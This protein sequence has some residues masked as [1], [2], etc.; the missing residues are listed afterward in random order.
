MLV[1]TKTHPQMN[2]NNASTLLY[3]YARDVIELMEQIKEINHHS[4]MI[5]DILKIEQSIDKIAKAQS[6]LRKIR[7]TATISIAK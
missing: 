3:V 5:D 1:L 2:T 7:E 6:M 4:S